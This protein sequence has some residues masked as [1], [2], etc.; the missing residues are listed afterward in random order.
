MCVFVGSKFCHFL[1]LDLLGWLKT[2]THTLTET[3]DDVS[4]KIQYRT[5][6][7]EF[8]QNPEVLADCNR[9]WWRVKFHPLHN[10]NNQGLFTAHVIHVSSNAYVWW[11]TLNFNAATRQFEPTSCSDQR[12]G[13]AIDMEKPTMAS[14]GNREKKT[15]SPFI[16]ENVLQHSMVSLAVSYQV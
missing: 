16:V 3:T 1:L 6:L 12:G 13:L 14:C 15:G 9:P 8:E 7:S 2:I 5:N 4:H 10:P 11:A